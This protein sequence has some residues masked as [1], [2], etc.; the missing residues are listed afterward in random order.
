[1][2]TFGL[3]WDKPS[4]FDQ[5]SPC[6][7]MGF[8]TIHQY[9]VGSLFGTQLKSIPA[10]SQNLSIDQSSPVKGRSPVS[11]SSVCDLLLN[12][13]ALCRTNAQ[14]NHSCCEIMFKMA[15]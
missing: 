1:M 12:G 14:G 15:V 4:G 8:E 11:P 10:C 2:Y 6:V 5:D 9:L 7:L 3:F 13:P